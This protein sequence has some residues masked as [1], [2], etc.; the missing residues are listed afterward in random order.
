MRAIVGQTFSV[1]KL[2]GIVDSVS[3]SGVVI[4]FARVSASGF[5]RTGVGELSV[6]YP[7]GGS[8]RVQMMLA[9]RPEYQQFEF[10]NELRV[11]VFS[12]LEIAQEETWIMRICPPCFAEISS[13]PE[14]G[15]IQSSS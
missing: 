15:Y 8:R 4:E 11:S 13:Q 2:T 3:L 6:V 7:C 1:A 5:T 10:L 9:I 12:A 14:D